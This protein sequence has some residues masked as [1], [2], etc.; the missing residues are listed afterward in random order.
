ML[1]I[2]LNHKHSTADVSVLGRTG[3]HRVLFFCVTYSF[4]F[5]LTS[6][7]DSLLLPEVRT[8]KLSKC[9]QFSSMAKRVL[10]KSCSL[11]CISSQHA[12]RRML[13]LLCCHCRCAAFG[14][15]GDKLW[16]QRKSCK[17]CCI[18]HYLHVKGHKSSSVKSAIKK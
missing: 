8:Y 11:F 4:W 3:Q 6:R 5:T 16:M 1:G 18:F 12:S 2:C 9:I 13:S 17:I 10:A 14:T 15:Y 7:N